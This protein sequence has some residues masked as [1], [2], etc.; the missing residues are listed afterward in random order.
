MEVSKE[1]KG[2]KREM[3]KLK[4][5]HLLLIWVIVWIAFWLILLMLQVRGSIDYPAGSC[6]E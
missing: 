4:K 2:T 6:W 5:P 1:N 3:I